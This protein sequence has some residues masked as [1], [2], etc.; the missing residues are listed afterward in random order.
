[1]PTCLVVGTGAVHWDSVI[2]A[3]FGLEPEDVP[4]SYDG[5]LLRLT[6]LEATARSAD[7][8]LPDP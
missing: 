6:E 2:C 3:L 5:Y 1:M 7:R 4:K 8:R